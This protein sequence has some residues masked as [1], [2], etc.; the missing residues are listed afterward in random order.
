[1]SPNVNNINSN[2]NDHYILLATSLKTVEWHF[3]NN[4]RIPLVV[5]PKYFIPENV[6]TVLFRWLKNWRLNSIDSYVKISSAT[7]W[8]RGQ[9]WASVLHLLKHT[10]KHGESQGLHFIFKIMFQIRIKLLRG[11]H[12]KVHFWLMHLLPRCCY[13][14]WDRGSGRWCLN[15]QPRMD[16][17]VSWDFCL[18]LLDKEHPLL[19]PEVIHK[20]SFNEALNNIQS[21]PKNNL[22]WPFQRTLLTVWLFTTI[23]L[24]NHNTGVK[25]YYYLFTSIFSNFD[26]NFP[27]YSCIPQGKKK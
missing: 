20:W 22:H 1:M 15:Y 16:P 17:P 7:Y 9:L 24:S 21:L 4:W 2:I 26:R 10:V 5:F 23:H 25:V 14:L 13:C 3:V 8:Q 19:S 12:K 18:I 6:Y 27:I 11:T